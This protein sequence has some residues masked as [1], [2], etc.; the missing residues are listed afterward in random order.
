M[1]VLVQYLGVPYC[2]INT[3]WILLKYE[4]FK[5]LEVQTLMMKT[6]K[7]DSIKKEII[8]IIERADKPL[9]VETLRKQIDANYVTIE[10]AIFSIII[11]ELQ[12]NP[13]ILAE[14]NLPFIPMKTSKSL[15]LIPKKL[16][17]GIKDEEERSKS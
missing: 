16:Y 1:Q 14:L 2:V 6:G 17:G 5:N 8:E 9:A 12:K 15:I 4:S 3:Y 11:E 10:R 13:K 7:S